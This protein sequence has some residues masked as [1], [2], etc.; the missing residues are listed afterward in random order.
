M[1]K[2]NIDLYNQNTMRLHC[3]AETVY[4]PESVDELKSIISELGNKDFYLL[5]A[6]SNVILPESISRPVV[7]LMKLDDRIEFVD[8]IVRVGCSVRV[9]KLIRFLQQHH[10]GGIEYLF[11][12][13]A[14]IGGLVYMNGGRGRKYNKAISD[15]LI[16]VDFLDLDDRKIHTYIYNKS[17]FSYRHSPFQDKNVILITCYFRFEEQDKETTEQL[18]NE[19]LEHS[20]NYLSADKPSCGSVFCKGNRVLFRLMR[21]M[22]VGGA[23]FSKKTPNWIS[24]V[25]HASYQDICK[26]IRR[27]EWLHRVFLTH[28]KLELKIIE[29]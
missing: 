20:K 10:Q 22:K 12:V 21:G 1:K 23:Q 4:Y 2:N 18:I 9:Q 29:E 15:Y 25:D 17:D 19:R 24:N 7:S 28:S 26:L 27:A 3:V 5:A 8:G 13:P 14:S 16:K 11:S 6:G